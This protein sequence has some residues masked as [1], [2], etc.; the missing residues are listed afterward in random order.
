MILSK[1]EASKVTL[2]GTKVSEDDKKRICLQLN[3]LYL[4][5]INLYLGLER[6]TEAEQLV[7]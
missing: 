3:K 7:T 1:I 2:T 4:Q 5:L 6:K